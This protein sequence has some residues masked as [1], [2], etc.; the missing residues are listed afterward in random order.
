[1]KC[2]MTGYE[3]QGHVNFCKTLSKTGREGGP[4]VPEGG[5]DAEYINLCRSALLFV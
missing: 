3:T 1:M 4:R 5:Y 2:S